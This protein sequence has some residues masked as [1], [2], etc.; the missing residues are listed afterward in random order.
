[1]AQITVAGPFSEQEARD[2]ARALGDSNHSVFSKAL[3]GA[4][5]FETG[6]SDWF[7]E[8]DTEAPTTKIFGYDWADIQARQQRRGR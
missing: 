5:G 1:M 6:E 3:V 8:R 2:T 4:D 7:V